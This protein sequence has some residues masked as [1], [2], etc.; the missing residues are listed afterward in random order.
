[1]SWTVWRRTLP[2]EKVTAPNPIPQTESYLMAQPGEPYPV[3]VFVAALFV[4]DAVMQDALSRLAER[5]GPIDY[6]SDAIP[7]DVTDYYASEMGKGLMRQLFS[8]ARKVTP[9]AIAEIKL[10]TNA[11][12]DELAEGGKRRINLD[13][14]YMDHNKVVLPSMKQGSQKIYLDKGVWADPTLRYEK[15]RFHPFDWTFPDFKDGRYHKPLMRIRELYKTG[16]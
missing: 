6:T 16:R 1:V 3:K 14:G 2:D 7:F 9:A 10:F 11:L 8:F 15:G 5:L 12:E 4:P 13:P